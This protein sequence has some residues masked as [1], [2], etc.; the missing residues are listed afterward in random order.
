MY[1]VFIYGFSKSYFLEIGNIVNIMQ[2]QQPNHLK[3][4]NWVPH[5]KLLFFLLVHFYLMISFNF[6]K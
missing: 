3:S 1:T 4:N 6:E 5:S 2:I